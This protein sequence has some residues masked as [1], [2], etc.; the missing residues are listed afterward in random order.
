MRH[1]V[2]GRAKVTCDMSAQK[3]NPVTRPNAWKVSLGVMLLAGMLSRAEGARIEKKA[4]DFSRTTYL[5]AKALQRIKKTG[6]L[7]GG[8]E[9]EYVLEVPT[10]GWWELHVRAAKWA[11]DLYLDGRFLIYTPFDSGVWETKEKSC[12]KVMNLR[13]DKGRHTLKFSRPWHP[14]LPWM[15]RFYLQ[16]ATDLTG[17]CRITLQKDHLAFR[18]GE[19]FAATLQ[20]GRGKKSNVVL[21]QVKDAAGG[22]PITT[23]EKRVPAGS[24]NFETAMEFPTDREGVFDVE[25]VGRDGKH[26]DRTIQYC[27]IDPR[28]PDSPRRLRKELVGVID[29]TAKAPDFSYGPTRV[30]QS[31]CGAYRESDDR[32]REKGVSA[33][34]WFAYKLNL[35]T[36][37]EPYL[38]EIEYPDDDRRTTPIVLVERY[39]PPEPA[40]GYFTGGVYPLSGRMLTQEFYFTPRDKD[41]RVLFYNWDS[42]QRAALGKIRIYRIKDGFP[43][44][45]YGRDGRMF[46]MYQE[47][48]MRFLCNFGATGKGDTWVNFHNTAERVGKLLNYAGIN[49]WNPTLAVYG[50]MLWPGKSLPGYKM[51]ILPPGPATLKEPF[52]KDVMRL[53][54]LTCEKY[55]LNF[56]GDLHIPLWNTAALVLNLD[57]RFGGKGAFDDDGYQKPWLTV[58]NKGEVGLRSSYKPY[59][60]PLYPG[61][62]EWISE[63]FQELADRYKDSPAFKGVSIRLLF[64]WTFAGWQSYQSIDW[65]YEDYTV[66][67]FEKETG[68]RIPVDREDPQRFRKRHDWLMT[69]AY[70]KWVDWRCQKIHQYHH[71]LAQTLRTG[72]PDSRL[73]L[74][75]CGWPSGTSGDGS[76]AKALRERGLDPDLYASDPLIVAYGGRG[77]PDGGN[78]GDDK[79]MNVAR[80][81]DASFSTA[82]I[83]MLAKA[84]G[85]GTVSALYLGTNHEGGYVKHKLL[86]YG[87]KEVTSNSKTIYPDS[88]VNP[89]GIHY[90]ERFTNAMADG[91][92]TWLSDGSHGYCLG[93]PALLRRFLAEYRAL[94][95]IG[96][97]QLGDSDPVA[98]WYGR[99]G[100]HGY[101]YLANRAYYEVDAE[102]S[103]SGTARLMRLSTGETAAPLGNVLKIRLAPYGFV[104][105]QNALGSTPRTIELKVP[106][107]Q[108]QL[109]GRQVRA[110]DKLIHAGPAVIQVLSLSPVDLRKAEKKLAQVKACLKQGHLW[111]ARQLLLHRDLIGLYEALHSYPPGLFHRKTP[112]MPEGAMLP[113]QILRRLADQAGAEVVDGATVS[114]A[115]S[116]NTV[117]ALE[118]REAVIGVEVPFTNRYRIWCSYA[119]GGDLRAPVLTLN[120]KRL[121]EMGAREGACASVAVSVPVALERGVQNL[122]VGARGGRTALLAL[123]LE[124]LFRDLPA[125][126]FRAIGPFKGLSKGGRMTTETVSAAMSKADFPEREVDLRKTYHVHGKTL[127][128]VVPRKGVAGTDPFA[129]NYI[130]LYKTFGEISQGGKGTIAYAVTHVASPQ[131]RE[132]RFSLGADY[133]AKIWVNGTVVLGPDVRPRTPPKKGETRFPVTLRKG[134]NEVLIKIHAGSAGNGFW[135]AVSDPGD[136]KFV[137]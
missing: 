11:T 116:G 129:G 65:G 1:V 16:S 36:V 34:S 100:K 108:T 49:L 70:R 136:L 81:R 80:A 75:G 14:G 45:R 61:V 97:K 126:R 135:L 86:G 24:G 23:I 48:P 5:S 113:P 38:M 123:F 90:L 73:Y 115:L 84:A 25:V 105:F 32:G 98:L 117:L 44:L 87:P 33:A 10:S 63:V 83:R 31:S 114:P 122:V 107:E 89:A 68:T 125:D 21:F 17:K 52:K 35:P 64:G 39:G 4:A 40:L 119:T 127:A 134:L 56:I 71:R 53:M 43:T 46:G 66:A 7:T 27:V 6:Y 59:Y 78:R 94:P 104:G 57:K 91:N 13:L 85:D 2:G 76:P 103:F 30:V 120:G 22:T 111:R 88:T 99:D 133:W 124:P 82:P 77:Y 93:Q 42:G 137:D 9:A 92:F 72:R 95:V 20:A 51:A 8:G 62:Q 28:K 69:N 54:L 60:N 58:S 3:E 112:A 109:V 96:M 18:K 55:G 50:G 132:A 41:P 12:F 102:V 15:T 121:E 79:P 130:D 106:Q 47:E 131:D 118:A 128:W 19:R 37:Q 74:F 26:L 67:L 110:V 101:F 29:A